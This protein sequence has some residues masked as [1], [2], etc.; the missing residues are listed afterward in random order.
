MNSMIPW[1]S[2]GEMTRLRREMDRLFDRFFEGW[3]L[4]AFVDKGPWAPSVDVSET[5][6]EVIV[7]AEIPGIDPKDLDVSVHGN[8]LTLRGERKKEHEEKDE[9]F[10]RKERVYGAFS[11]SVQLPTEVDVAKV[12]AGYKDGVLKVN[13]PKSKAAAAKKIEIKAE[14]SV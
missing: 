5:S 3:P 13:L 7:K 1:S 11:R 12:K 10:H 9:N 6:K 14:T 8:V 2:G 4:G